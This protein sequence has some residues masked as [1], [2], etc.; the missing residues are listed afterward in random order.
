MNIKN[1]ILET[2]ENFAQFPQVNIISGAEFKRKYVDLEDKILVKAIFDYGEDEGLSMG[3]LLGD[4]EYWC[5]TKGCIFHYESDDYFADYI[6]AELKDDAKIAILEDPNS[7]NP[8]FFDK[9][10]NQVDALYSPNEEEY[11][12][13]GLVVYNQNILS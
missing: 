10:K 2:I 12:Y 1:I 4:G 9:I 13:L 6:Y 3:N 11:G 7:V 8:D 5:A